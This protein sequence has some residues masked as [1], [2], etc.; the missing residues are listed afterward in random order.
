MKR[1]QFIL[2]M[3]S[4][5][6]V[7]CSKNIQTI[8]TKKSVRNIRKAVFSTNGE[9]KVMTFNIRVDTF[10]DIG[11]RSWDKRKDIAF[12][13]IAEKAPDI[14]GIQE[15]EY[16]QAMEI[17]KNVSGYACYTAGRNDGKKRG[18]ACSIFYRKDRFKLLD[19]GTFWFSKNPQK[20][21]SKYASA[22]N[23][24]ICSW[25]YLMDYNQKSFYV[26]NVH[27][28]HLS[29]KAREKSV[30]LLVER[31]QERKTKEPFVVI[32]DFNVGLKNP[33]FDYLLKNDVLKMKNA[34]KELKQDELT[35]TRHHFSGR[36]GLKTDHILYKDMEIF[37]ISIDK[38]NVRGVYPSDHFPIC[39]RMKI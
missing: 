17:C 3:V 25:V 36:R 14:F 7:G 32:G 9:L 5:L 2:L 29:Q 24:R 30:R 37:D 33:I 11:K 6:F 18:E 38:R 39:V 35:W 31:I 20:P 34:W 19:S 21:G 28:D 10:L 13:L 27:L 15:A 12:D 4:C 8:Q 22:F 16:S 26:Y 1:I 23:P